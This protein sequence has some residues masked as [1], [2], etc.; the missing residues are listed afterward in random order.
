MDVSTMISACIGLGASGE[1]TGAASSCVAV[2]M[3]VFIG[4]KVGARRIGRGG[5][6]SP[7]TGA[8]TGLVI[9][10]GDSESCVSPVDS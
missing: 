1:R 4:G 8:S 10:V 3:S 6:A 5:N 9:A 2:S 7:C